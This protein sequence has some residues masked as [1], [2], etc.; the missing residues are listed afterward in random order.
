LETSTDLQNWTVFAS[1]IVLGA[2]GATNV[3]VAPTSDKGFFRAR[4]KR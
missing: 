3:L 1:S 4:P 2:M